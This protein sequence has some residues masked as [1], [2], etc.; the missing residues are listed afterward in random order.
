MQPH[1]ELPPQACLGAA[2]IKTSARHFNSTDG[3]TLLWRLCCC[4]TSPSIHYF[5][6][7]QGKEG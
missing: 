1:Q 3:I 4:R 6:H 7:V 2:A 5:K